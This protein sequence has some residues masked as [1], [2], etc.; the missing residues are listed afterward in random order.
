[1]VMVMHERFRS[2]QQGITLIVVLVILIVIAL[3]G[4]TA[5]HMSINNT[6]ISTNSRTQAMT[7]E[8]AEA[9][10]RQ[11]YAQAQLAATWNSTSTQQQAAPTTTYDLA[12]QLS[13]STLCDGTNPAYPACIVLTCITQ[14]GSVVSQ[15]SAN[16]QS[17]DRLD[18]AGQLQ[19]VSQT[20]YVGTA[21]MFNSSMQAALFQTESVGCMPD[22]GST[23]VVMT[24]DNG[25]TTP[26]VAA[27]NYSDTV[28]VISR[29]ILGTN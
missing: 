8:A 14:G 22:S 10:T 27:S 26:Q 24:T 17:T 3:L 1:M 5:M 19:T 12:L 25:M 20:T 18:Q 16:C 28:V 4:V 23:C 15:T 9:G 11:A 6:H 2:G 29:P 13:G 21:P 7:F